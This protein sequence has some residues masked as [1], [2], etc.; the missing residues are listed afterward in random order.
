M[1]DAFIYHLSGWIDSS[2]KKT[3]AENLASRINLFDGIVTLTGCEKDKYFR[4]DLFLV[5]LTKVFYD[6]DV[7]RITES[8]T[9]EGVRR[10][11]RRVSVD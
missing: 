4:E 1:Q 8:Q 11:V 3:L 9:P 2:W 7:N 5:F 10:T 6:K